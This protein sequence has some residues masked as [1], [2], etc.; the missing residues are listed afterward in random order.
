MRRDFYNEQQAAEY[1]GVSVDS[2]KRGINSG[3]L[4][5]VPGMRIDDNGKQLKRN[6]MAHDDLVAW[7]LDTTNKAGK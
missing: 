4:K 7:M 6:I 2:I 1:V 5:T 3:Y